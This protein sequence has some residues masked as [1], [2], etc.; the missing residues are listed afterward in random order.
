METWKK[1]Y[2]SSGLRFNNPNLSEEENKQLYKDLYSEDGLGYNFCLEVGVCGALNEKTSMMIH[3]NQLEQLLKDITSEFDH[4]YINDIPYFK[5][6]TFS[7]ESFAGYLNQ[8][9]ID[10][11]KTKNLSVSELKLYSNEFTWIKIKNGSN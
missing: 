5:E 9:I 3:Y 11:L 10:E 6:S 1:I 7:L 2:F 4:Q 8:K